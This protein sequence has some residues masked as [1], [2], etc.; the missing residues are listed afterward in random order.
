MKNRLVSLHRAFTLIELLV[1]IAIIAILAGLLLSA[2]ARSKARAK[3]AECVSNLKQVALGLRM[4]ANDNDAKFPWAIDVAAGG[5][6]DSP[7]WADHFRTCANELATPRILLCTVDKEKTAASAWSMLAGFDNV[8][9][10]VGLSAEESKSQTLLTG[11]ANIIGGGGGVNLSWNPFVGSSIDAMW[12]D[13]LH[14][15]RGNIALS[16]G[17]VQTMTTLQLRDQISTAL[18]AGSTNV[19]ISKPQGVL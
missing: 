2:L 6:K 9:Y 3:T 4:W 5:S 15:D 19:V 8:S 7:E 10:F 1:V 11:D 14:R 16:D 17:S 13:T 12:D 18:A